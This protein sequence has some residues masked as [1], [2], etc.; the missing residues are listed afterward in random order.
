MKYIQATIRFNEK[1]IA[2]KCAEKI[3]P[4]PQYSDFYKNQLNI[5]IT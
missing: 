2:A 3:D 1:C 5:N 4:T